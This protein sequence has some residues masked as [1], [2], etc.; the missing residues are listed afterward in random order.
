MLTNVSSVDPIDIGIANDRI[1][2]Q[3]GLKTLPN[4]VAISDDGC[5]LVTAEMRA[6]G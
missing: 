6:N 4:K 5:V 1:D 3:R 2:H